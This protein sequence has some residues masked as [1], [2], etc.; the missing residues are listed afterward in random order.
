MVASRATSA[1]VDVPSPPGLSYLPFQ[2]AGIAYVLN[3]L[4]AGKRGVLIADEMGLG[5]TV[6]AIGV[7]NAKLAA[8]TDEE[9][10]KFRVLVICPASLRQNWKRELE[11][12]LVRPLRVEILDKS[13]PARAQVVVSN[14]ERVRRP[15]VKDTL[16][17]PWDVLIVDEAHRLKDPKS[18]QTK[19]ILGC[20][21]TK[22]REVVVGLESFAKTLLFLTGTPILAR[23]VEA[24]PLLQ[25]LD[26]SFA[27]FGF[28]KRYCNAHQEYVGRT[29]VWNF[30][31]A[32]HLDELQARLR[33]S[34][35][36]R[37]L[38]SEV[39]KELPPKRRE[40]IV[41]DSDEVKKL[42]ADENRGIAKYEDTIAEVETEARLALADG[43]LDAYHAAAAK[44]EKISSVVFTEIASCRKAL[45]VAKVPL[46]LEHCDV[47]LEADGKILVFTHHHEVTDAIAQ[48]YAGRCI[49]I[50]GRTPMADR[51]ALVDRFQTDAT[52]R[53][54]VLSIAAAGV[55]LTLTAAQHVVFAELDWTPA[56]VTQAEDRA[57]RIG[58]MSSVLVQHLVFNGSLDARMVELLIQKQNIFDR[59]LDASTE[60]KLTEMSNKT[61]A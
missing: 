16:S 25:T 10:E 6:Q 36:V 55:G 8:M 44:L 34:I 20:T 21:K 30:S 61:K 53:V 12:W 28:L 9:T 13:L 54:A 35:M 39:L 59:M 40:I 29:L 43:N 60:V 5:K 24:Q 18:Q 33:A 49:V 38:K 15:E 37:R 7:L 58:Q 56:N 11:R 26:P 19:A 17:F 14:F 27:G 47:A 57:H 50:D 31:G 1:D 51:Q 4:E 22:K 3:A 52:I 46:V 23:P 41:L 32:S 48:H 42:I 2:R 45:A